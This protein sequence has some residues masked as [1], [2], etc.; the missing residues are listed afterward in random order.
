[1]GFAVDGGGGARERETGRGGGPAS[2]DMPVNMVEAEE[3]EGE[4]AEAEEE[5]KGSAPGSGGAP[6]PHMSSTGASPATPPMAHPPSPVP[7]PPLPPPVDVEA[8]TAPD[9][10][11][12]PPFPFVFTPPLF[13]FPST[14]ALT[15]SACRSAG[16]RAASTRSS[17]PRKIRMTVPSCCWFSPGASV[18]GHTSGSTRTAVSAAPPAR[19][20]ASATPSTHMS[21]AAEVSAP[22]SCA[23]ILSVASHSGGPSPGATLPSATRAL[24]RTAAAVVVSAAACSR[25][26]MQQGHENK[27]S[28][29]IGARLYLSVN[30][31]TDAQMSRRRFNISVEC[32]FS[33]TPATSRLMASGRTRPAAAT[34]CRSASSCTSTSGQGRIL[35]ALI[36]LL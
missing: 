14:T 36:S 4:A 32:L 34:T 33:K 15:S 7:P 30:A 29:D 9:A 3:A 26:T 17:M 1:M 25:G 31:R 10:A 24:T 28:T 22:A 16:M 18:S 21:V 2:V 23:N 12:T 20:T 27:H 8:R 13:P 6:P 19:P 11:F 5:V 35:V